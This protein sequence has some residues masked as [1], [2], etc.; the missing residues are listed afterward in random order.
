MKIPFRVTKG[1]DLNSIK[2]KEVTGFLDN[3]TTVMDEAVWGHD[4]AKRK[5]YSNYGTK[6]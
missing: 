6:Y 5:N 2:Q 1:I 3:L 4:Q